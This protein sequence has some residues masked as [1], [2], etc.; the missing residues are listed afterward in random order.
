M[1]FM[2]LNYWLNTVARVDKTRF[3]RAACYTLQN[4]N[5]NN[6]N[7]NY[8]YY[9]YNPLLTIK[10][11]KDTIFKAFSAVWLMSSFFYQLSVHNN[12]EE[13]RHKNRDIFLH[14]PW[15]V[16]FRLSVANTPLIM[17]FPN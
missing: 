1:M 6:N 8:Y 14:C 17:K 7:N 5:N 12:L 11:N 13:R 15:G 9:Y 10:Q 4:N 2:Q 16:L 3:L